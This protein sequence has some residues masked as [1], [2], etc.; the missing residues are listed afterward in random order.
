MRYDTTPMLT[1]FLC[2]LNEPGNVV[3][4]QAKVREAV[5]PK[6]TGLVTRHILELGI[7]FRSMTLHVLK[8]SV[9]RQRGW[10]TA[11]RSA[12]ESLWEQSRV[13]RVH[14]EA[15]YGKAHIQ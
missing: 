9:K 4:H 11:L 5:E 2:P 14:Q 8:M 3:D 1:G 15:E 13:S 6:V 7:I 10:R 12:H